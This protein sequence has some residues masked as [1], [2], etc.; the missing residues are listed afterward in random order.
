MPLGTPATPATRISPSDSSL[1]YLLF[2]L[3]VHRASSRIRRLPCSLDLSQPQCLHGLSHPPPHHT[4]PLWGGDLS[5]LT[6]RCIPSSWHSAWHAV[7]PGKS[8]WAEQM[9][10]GHTCVSMHAPSRS[11]KS[12]VLG[13]CCSVAKSCPTLCDPMDCST[14]GFPLLHSLL[15]VA[16]THV[17]WVSDA[18]RPS[19]PLSPSSPLTFSLS[20]HQSLFQ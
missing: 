7:I 11:G 12:L 14:P 2:H 9:K 8:L 17:D 3:P 4:S 13:V 6:D 16:Q 15:E 18:I 20:Q 19:H 10:E 1:S 5:R